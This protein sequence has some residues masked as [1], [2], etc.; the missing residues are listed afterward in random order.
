M[1]VIAA[2]LTA[3]ALFGVHRGDALRAAEAGIGRALLHQPLRL[4]RVPLA[5]FGLHVRAAG[6]TKVGAFIIVQTV[7]TQHR[8]DVLRG[9]RHQTLSISVF[10]T[11]DEAAVIVARKEPV[12]ERR[13]QAANMQRAGRAG[14]EADSHGPGSGHQGSCLWQMQ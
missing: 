5:P 3:A 4:L 6:A 1:P 11:Q 7:T 14:S 12:E 13:A 2:G 8:H 9:A 10:K